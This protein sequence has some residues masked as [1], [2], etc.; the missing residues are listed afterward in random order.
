MASGAARPIRKIAAM[1]ML[2]HHP[3]ATLAL[4]AA[5]AGLAPAVLAQTTVAQPWVRGTVAQQKATGAFMQL[6]S[7][8]GGRLISVASPAAGVVEMHEMSMQG[9][10]M[11][12]RALP[13]G[14]DL[15]AGQAVAL[16]PGGY[17]LMLMD[18]KAPL[19]P[20]DSVAL[21]LVVQG[22]GGVRETIEVQA[23]VKALGAAAA[24]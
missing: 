20:G 4:L 7:A 1:N 22:K 14:L 12:M 16:K 9:S 15:P 17:H 10:T 13:N 11:K 24:H 8:Q 21:T 5:S 19:K 2:R 18:L 6:T 3:L 23:P